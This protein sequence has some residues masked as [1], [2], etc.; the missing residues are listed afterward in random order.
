MAVNTC[1]D[2]LAKAG[3]DASD[4]VR[5]TY[6]TTFADTLRKN[7]GRIAAPFHPD[8]IIKTERTTIA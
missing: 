1:I 6:H 2:T 4:R 5:F 8:G 7:A 3:M